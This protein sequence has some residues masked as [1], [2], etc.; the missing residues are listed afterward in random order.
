MSK[1][2]YLKQRLVIAGCATTSYLAS[3]L[4]RHVMTFGLNEQKRAAVH[5]FGGR[6]RLA[7]L[8]AGVEI[9]S[10]FIP[11][12]LFLACSLPVFTLHDRYLGF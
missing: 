12:S 9:S 6:D 11:L 3:A 2:T 5:A 4:P 1:V 7:C 10:L 8:T